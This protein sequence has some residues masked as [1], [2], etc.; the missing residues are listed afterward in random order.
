MEIKYMEEHKRAQRLKWEASQANVT[1]SDEVK[2]QDIVPIVS[3]PINLPKITVLK[4]T[5][6]NV[7]VD[8]VSINLFLEY[9][10][11]NNIRRT[12]LLYGKTLTENERTNIH[13]DVIYEP[14]QDDKGIPSFYDE[15]GTISHNL[16]KLMG[17]DLLGFILV[18]STRELKNNIKLI[19]ERLRKTEYKNTNLFTDEEILIITVDEKDHNI[20]AFSTDLKEQGSK[21]VRIDWIPKGVKRKVSTDIIHT[22]FYRLNRQEHLI[23]KEDIYTFIYLRKNKANISELYLQVAD[24]H[25]I[26]AIGVIYGELYGERAIL[27][28]FSQDDTLIEIFFQIIN[29]GK[30][31]VMERLQ[32]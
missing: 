3:T 5:C 4:T 13:V 29:A 2:V 26:L 28:I 7:V 11:T 22:G 25:L 18:T 8:D 9:I 23:T 32:E 12:G 20:E 30:E 31:Q 24:Y 16:S 10:K 19:R 17:F 14:S 6:D 21:N 27:S 15:F 1:R